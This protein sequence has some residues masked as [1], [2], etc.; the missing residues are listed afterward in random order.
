MNKAILMG[1]LTKDPE[2]RM[3]NNQ[4]PVATFTIAIDRNFK[5]ASG[6]KPTD[7]IDCVAWRKTAELISQHFTKGRMIAVVGSIQVRSWDDKEGNKRY[8][9]EVIVDEFSF[10]GD[11][12]QQTQST[13]YAT[14]D[15]ASM[16]YEL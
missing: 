3:T 12:K 13:S 16:P 2:L 8:T 4:I 7:F 15:G 5:D 9:T 14:E 1:R 6:N 11:N 10:T